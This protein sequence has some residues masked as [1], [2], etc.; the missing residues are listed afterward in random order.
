[1]QHAD[2][3]GTL[4]PDS[5]A[6]AAGILRAAGESGQRR[7]GPQCVVSGAAHGVMTR[8]T[9]LAIPGCVFLRFLRSF[10]GGGLLECRTSSGSCTAVS[11]APC[12]F[13]ASMSTV[14][15]IC[16]RHCF[17]IGCSP[18]FSCQGMLWTH[19]CT[20]T[21]ANSSAQKPVIARTHQVAYFPKH[22]RRRQC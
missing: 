7:A 19:A 2:C 16:R 11:N 10:C 22:E 21:H 13:N 1:M 4:A 14:F 17:P 3:F 5:L 8:C 9:G 12:R 18:S 6:S 15:M 20:D